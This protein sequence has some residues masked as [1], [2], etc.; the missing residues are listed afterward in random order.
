MRQLHLFILLALLSALPARSQ[1]PVHFIQAHGNASVNKEQYMAG[2]GLGWRR[3]V[4]SVSAGKGTGFDGQF[5]KPGEWANKYVR[6]EM[7][8]RT[9]V[10]PD[11]E[12]ANSYIE[13]CSSTYEVKMARLGFTVFVLKNEARGRNP[14]TGPHFGVDAVFARTLERQSL[15]YKSNT[16]ETRYSYSGENRFNELGASSH[17]G[18][19]LA[20]MRDHL[21]VDLRAGITF[22]YPFTKEVNLKSPYT[23]NRFEG[24]VTFSWRFGKE[25]DAEIEDA[26][27]AIVREKI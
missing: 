13:E 18:W 8:D 20:F 10:E 26:E 27:K 17:V 2:Y 15:T 21:F 23:G 14:F 7:S 16:A 24:Q 5:V 11:E 9:T 25:N 4:F 19:Q 1:R 22:Y 12:P 3:I 6:M